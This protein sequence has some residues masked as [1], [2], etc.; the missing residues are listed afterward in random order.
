MPGIVIPKTYEKRGAYFVAV[1][2]WYTG[3][4]RVGDTFLDVKNILRKHDTCI[5][6]GLALVRLRLRYHKV[7][8]DQKTGSCR[9]QT[10]QG[11]ESGCHGTGVVLGRVRG[12]KYPLTN[13]TCVKVWALEPLLE[14]S[15]GIG[16]LQRLSSD[17]CCP[18]CFCSQGGEQPIEAAVPF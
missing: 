8:R 12:A 14:R 4:F 11:S 10:F 13:K 16:F 3:K 18:A 5:A 15:A 6:A 9:P 17:S 7:R 1:R 2:W